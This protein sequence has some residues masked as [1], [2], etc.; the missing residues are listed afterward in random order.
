M[1]LVLDTSPIH[2]PAEALAIAKARGVLPTALDTEG[3][4]ATWSAE[5]RRQSVFSAR[6]TNAAYLASLEKQIEAVLNGRD[7]AQARAI[8]KGQ[9]TRLGYT[10]KRGFP[11]DKKL[12]I[13]PARPGSITD[14][15]SNARLDLILDTQ[16]ALITGR[17][18]QL[19]GREPAALKQEPA[20]E[21]VRLEARKAP[22][23]WLA[24]WKRAG[25]KVIQ[26]KSGPRLIAHKLAPVWQRLGSSA[27]FSDALDVDHS[28]FAFRSGMG[29]E[30]IRAATAKRYKVTAPKA[31]KPTGRPLPPA[32]TTVA[33]TLPPRLLKALEQAL[34][35]LGITTKAG[36]IALKPTRARD[37][38]PPP[39][40]PGRASFLR[41]LAR[42]K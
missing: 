2:T 8:L 20:L 4:R 36:Q 32:V 5:L 15:A 38:A 28:P 40:P 7:P 30:P 41:N 23:D 26:T 24:R 34:A 1:R 29:T 12:G 13:P 3:I 11:G 19:A 42:M 18:E 22:R 37:E 16:V 17:A 14:L 6:T 31:S 33:K 10:A 27:F 39:P 25:G 9:L 35:P 21:L